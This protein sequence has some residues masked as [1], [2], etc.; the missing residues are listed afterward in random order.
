MAER[1]PVVVVIFLHLKE[2]H[3]FFLVGISTMTQGEVTDSEIPFSC[4]NILCR[5]ARWYIFKPKIRIWVN[6]GG[7]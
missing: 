5:V 2:I 4:T 3:L 7:P 6:F 1:D